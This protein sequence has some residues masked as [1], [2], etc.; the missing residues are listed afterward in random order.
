MKNSIEPTTV[1]A[2]IRDD[3]PLRHCN[4]APSYRTVRIKLTEKQ[5]EALTLRRTDKIGGQVFHESISRAI[6]E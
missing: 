3:A 5:Q 6:I 2:V 4:D 1:T